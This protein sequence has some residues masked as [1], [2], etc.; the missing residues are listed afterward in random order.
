M[1]TK[2]EHY[3]YYIHVV[4]LAGYVTLIQHCIG[5]HDR[6]IWLTNGKQK[7]KLLKHAYAT[8]EFPCTHLEN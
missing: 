5:F 6:G 2:I 8:M 7:L 4:H 3:I 1:Q